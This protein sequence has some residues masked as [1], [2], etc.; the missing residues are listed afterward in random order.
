MR[1]AGVASAATNTSRELGGVFGIALLGAVVTSAFKR[2]FQARLIQGGLSKAAAAGIVTRAGASSAAG[3]ATGRLTP[4][5]D[6]S[7]VHAMDVTALIGTLFVLAGA[8]VAYIWLPARHSSIGIC[9]ATHVLARSSAVRGAC[10]LAQRPASWSRS[11]ASSRIRSPRCGRRTS[12]VMNGPPSA[13][14]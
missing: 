7:F 2:G 13:T 12:S 9:S 4:A 8:V 10:R 6:Q 11:T 5:V 3:R 14:R 1:H